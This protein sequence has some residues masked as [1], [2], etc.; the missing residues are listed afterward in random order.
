MD[1]EEKHEAAIAQ[2]RDYLGLSEED[3]QSLR[4]AL[5]EDT[6][7]DICGSCGQPLKK[8]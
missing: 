8:K 7:N 2:V 6:F 4:N 1:V 3:I 5:L